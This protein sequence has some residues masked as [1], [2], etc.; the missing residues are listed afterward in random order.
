MR[1][2]EHPTLGSTVPQSLEGAEAEAKASASGTVV[3]I[4]RVKRSS[5]AVGRT[6][7][8][9]AAGGGGDTRRC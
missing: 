3:H 4:Q 8:D 2:C 6:W 1:H 7:P 9:T 5:N